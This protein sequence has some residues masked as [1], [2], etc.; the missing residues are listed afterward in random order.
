MGD[1][2]KEA[3]ITNGLKLPNYRLP[4]EAEWEYAAQALIG[5]GLPGDENQNNRRIYPWDGHTVRNRTDK[6]LGLI[7]ANFKRGLGDYG[8]VAGKLNDGA[9]VTEEVF[10]YWPN[11]YGLY[12]MAG[13]VAEWVYDVYRPLSFQDFDDLNSFR[14]NPGEEGVEDEA[15]GYDYAGYQ[16]LIN[17]KVRVYKG[18]SWKDI[19]YWLSPGNR[20]FLSQD[21]STAYIGFRCAM[22][23]AGGALEK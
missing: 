2:D 17:D 12:N 3:T 21:S 1:G 7:N 10:S 4:T 13:N 18:G 8:G 11:D 14:G 6:N 20:R 19:A 22:I 5:T 16:S 9:F 15:G 23:R